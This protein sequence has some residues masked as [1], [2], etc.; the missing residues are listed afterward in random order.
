[1]S[2]FFEVFYRILLLIFLFSADALMLA[3]LLW[4][5]FHCCRK[6]RYLLTI[7][8]SNG[9]SDTSIPVNS[10][11]NAVATIRDQ[12]GNAIPGA[13]FDSAPNW[14]LADPTLA[15]FTVVDIQTIAVTGV[16]A[17]VTNLD[18]VGSYLGNIVT[19]QAVVTVT[20]VVGG[21]NVTIE[22]TTPAA[23]ASLPVRP[24]T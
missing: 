12:G 1:M 13:V 21:F 7:S 6:Q 3:A 10:T 4:A 5:I 20:A 16:A 9:M 17:G 22:W 8:W 18:V 23:P 24:L 19:A 2:D 14:T 15:S 11:Q